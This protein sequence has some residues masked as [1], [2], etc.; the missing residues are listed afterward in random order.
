MCSWTGSRVAVYGGKWQ[1]SG[2]EWRKMA[3][4]R[5]AFGLLGGEKQVLRNAALL[6]VCN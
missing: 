6:Q 4:I 2:S 1:S 3:S 5:V